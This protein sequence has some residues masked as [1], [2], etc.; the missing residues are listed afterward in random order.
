MTTSRKKLVVFM[1][2][3]VFLMSCN[4]Q[5]NRRQQSSEIVNAS[6]ETW[7]DIVARDGF[8]IANVPEV[9]YENILEA[10]LAKY[11]GR[12]IFVDFWTT[13]CVACIRAMQTMKPLKAEMKK[14]GVV[15]IYIT[16]DLSPKETWKTMLPDIGGIHY[17]LTTEQFMALRQK[18]E[19][20]GFPTYMIFDKKGERT[21]VRAGFPGNEAMREEL[22]NVW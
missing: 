22:A 1:L 18:Y 21:F 8:K 3:S 4:Q 11:Y 10:I 12:A 15:T 13:G 16:L 19:I 20:R 14:Q 9:E 17:Y 6:H 5:T 7:E 2:L